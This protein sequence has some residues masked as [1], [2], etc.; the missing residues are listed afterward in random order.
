MKLFIVMLGKT[1]I[2]EYYRSCTNTKKTEAEALQLVKIM[3]PVLC[4]LTSTWSCDTCYVFSSICLHE[5]V[6]MQLMLD[7]REN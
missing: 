3:M 4:F 1:E 5:I 7:H 6:M 2:F